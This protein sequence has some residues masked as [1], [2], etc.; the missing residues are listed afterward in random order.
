MRTWMMCSHLVD[1][2]KL[3]DP[4][5]GKYLQDFERD[6][7]ESVRK[8]PTFTEWCGYHLFPPMAWVGENVTYADWIKFIRYEGKVT[9]M[10]IGS[11]IGPALRRLIDAHVCFAVTVN[12]L[13]IAAPQDI[14]EPGFADTSY[15]YQTVFVYLAMQGP[16][17]KIMGRFV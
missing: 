4:E 10:R 11:N 3:D 16:M 1:S 8:M 6:L 7:A 15:W 2:T 17:F 9:K 12:V 13:K 5:K 14:T